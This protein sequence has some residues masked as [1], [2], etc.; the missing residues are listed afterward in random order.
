MSL[1][2][3]PLSLPCEVG[4][5]IAYKFLGMEK[6]KKSM[7]W[8]EAKHVSNKSSCLAWRKKHLSLFKDFACR[9][10]GARNQNGTSVMIGHIAVQPFPWT[11]GP[12]GTDGDLEIVRSLILPFV[13][14]RLWLTA[15]QRPAN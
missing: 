8:H 13:S 10:E 2:A 3:A 12:A 7:V 1:T 5:T 4:R 15:F 14:G 11:V 9:P 6:G